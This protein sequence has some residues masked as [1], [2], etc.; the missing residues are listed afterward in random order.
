[1]DRK[2]FLKTGMLGC[3]AI[4]SL[5]WLGSS[6]EK[7]NILF[8]GGTNF[9][10]PAIIEEALK[11]GHH[12]TLFNRGKTDPGLFPTLKQLRGNRYPDRGSGLEALHTNQTWDAVIDTWSGEPGCVYETARLLENRAD[13]YVYISSIAT[14]RNYK[15]AG[16][17]EEGPL[18][19][20]GEHI[21]S[22]NPDLSYPVRKRASEQAVAQVY[23]S[24]GI[25]HR[26]TSIQG[27]DGGEK[28]PGN[29]SSAAYWGFRFLSGE[30]VLVPDDPEAVLQYI[31]VKD[32]ARFVVRSIEKNMTGAFNLVG[33]RNP[34]PFR[35]YISTWKEITG[36]SSEIVRVSRSFLNRHNVRPFADIPLW[37][38]LD[39]PEP[40]FYQISNDRAVSH[41]LTYRPL[42]DTLKD[43][44]PGLQ[45]RT[46]DAISR[47]L[48]RERELKLLKLWSKTR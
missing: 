2:Q 34:L 7:L 47:G 8:L 39:E 20:A 43:I 22:F 23:G 32:M 15:K 25:I 46:L 24:K 13:R 3:L 42:E 40:G 12:V 14:Y 6:S 37:I 28:D 45:G 31:D 38:P 17:T 33:P 44:M 29:Q 9:V 27:F 11:R 1:M 48:D 19:D 16:M 10:G 4:P 41:G 26:C 36:S 21:S 35:E 30:K 18:L 5:S